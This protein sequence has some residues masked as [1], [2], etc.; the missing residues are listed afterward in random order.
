MDTIEFKP[1]NYP[2]DLSDAQWE[3]T[4]EYFPQGPNSDHHKRSLV[5]AVLYLNNNGCKWRALPHE[6]PPYSTVHSFCRRAR[7]S[8]LWEKVLQAIA[9]KTRVK[10]GRNA[11]PSYGIIDSQSVK[12][13]YASDERGFDGGKKQKVERDILS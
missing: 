12:T 3:Q 9:E 7:L 11:S 13:I 4:A 8:G 10:A 5:N 2:S 6:Y 1:T